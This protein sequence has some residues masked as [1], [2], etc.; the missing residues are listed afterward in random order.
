[1]ALLKA[2]PV[3]EP[4]AACESAQR[5]ALI[6]IVRDCG[7]TG[8]GRD[9]AVKQVD[10]LRDDPVGTVSY[11]GVSKGDQAV[12]A[13]NYQSRSAKAS[14]YC[15][16]QLCKSIYHGSCLLH[17]DAGGSAFIPSAR[18]RWRT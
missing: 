15:R 3:Q 17:Q 7:P 1:M 11:F 13:G 6:A 14:H 9:S 12:E 8:V 4:G 5:N 18:I 2:D 16:R 10:D